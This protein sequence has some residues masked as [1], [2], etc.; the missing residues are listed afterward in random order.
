MF[1][2]LLMYTRIFFPLS[3][4]PMYFKFIVC[5][6]YFSD[7]LFFMSLVD[8]NSMYVPMIRVGEKRV[9]INLR[10]ISFSRI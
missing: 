10:D 7:S 6:R 1:I 9:E 8:L 4:F 3:S 5:I 2:I